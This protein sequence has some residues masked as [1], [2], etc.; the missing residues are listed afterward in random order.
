M[1]LS[2]NG[3]SGLSCPFV[4]ETI[5]N[6]S[7]SRSLFS[8]FEFDSTMER[9]RPI[10]LSFAVTA[11][12]CLGPKFRCAGAEEKGWEG[13]REEYEVKVGAGDLSRSRR[14]QC[15]LCLPWLH[16]RGTVVP[17]KP[18]ARPNPP[19]KRARFGLS[20]LITTI[21]CALG[22]SSMLRVLGILWLSIDRRLQ[23]AGPRTTMTEHHQNLGVF[24]GL[25]GTCMYTVRESRPPIALED[26]PLR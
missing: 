14:S 17:E 25:V 9:I 15:L 16:L 4:V 6:F 20:S 1:G 23:A 7:S 12:R 26:W 8:C 18:C 3:Y 10:G 5:P 13:G 11:S 19:R 22:Y 2:R 21:Q 24:L